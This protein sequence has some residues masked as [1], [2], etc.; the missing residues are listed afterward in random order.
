MTVRT[1]PSSRRTGVH[2]L[3]AGL[4]LALLGLAVTMGC[5]GTPYFQTVTGTTTPT[6]DK[7]TATVPSDAPSKSSLRM[8]PFLFLSDSKLQPNNPLFQELTGLRDQVTEELKLPPGNTLVKVYL[9]EQRDRYEQFMT[10]NYPHLPKRRAFFVA[11]PR[12]VGAPADLLVYTYVGDRI[13]QDLRHELTHALLHSVLAAVPLWLD[14]G[15][16]EFFETPPGNDG[17]NPEHLRLLRAENARPNLARLEGLIEVKDMKPAEYR[18]AWAW[19]HLML[20]GQPEARRVLL[21]YLRELRTNPQPGPLRTRLVAVWP[22]PEEA[23]AEHLARLVP[24]PL[25]AARP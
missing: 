7:P 11:Q 16:A 5:S 14:E 8:G 2:P 1:S 19:V 9:F 18:E 21:A 15:I 24:S 12:F 4:T 6:S 25:A 23:L 10:K 17:L 20:R 3:A 22:R 13:Q